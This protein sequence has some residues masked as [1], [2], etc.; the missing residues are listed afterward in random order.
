MRKFGHAAEPWTTW[1]ILANIEADTGNAVAAAE[2]RAKAIACYR[3]YRRDGGEN[4]YRD[5]R[6]SFEVTQ[7][8]ANGDPTAAASHLQQL[9]ADPDYASMLPFIRAL[10]AIVAGS[11][12]G[13]LADAPNLRYTMAAEI[14]LLIET[15]DITG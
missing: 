8:L 6:V 7:Y 4:H 14:L 2:A 10:Q 13:S 9:A 5:G 12:D 3:A 15:L 11:R 1:S